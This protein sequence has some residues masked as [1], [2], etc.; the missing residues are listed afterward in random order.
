MVTETVPVD[1]ILVAMELLIEDR[2]DGAW[3]GEIPTLY[4]LW[5]SNKDRARWLLDRRHHVV[6]LDG[7]LPEPPIKL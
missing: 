3:E 7:P 4:R 6:E 1:E 2:G 5:R